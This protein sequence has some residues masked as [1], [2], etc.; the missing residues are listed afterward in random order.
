VWN[1]ANLCWVL[2]CVALMKVERIITPVARVVKINRYNRD[3]RVR[4]ECT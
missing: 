2:C 4:T 3:T 1:D